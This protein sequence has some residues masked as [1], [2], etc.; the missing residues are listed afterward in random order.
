MQTGACLI[1]TSPRALL[2]FNIDTRRTEQLFTNV[3]I[4]WPFVHPS[5]YLGVSFPEPGYLG[6][7]GGG[8]WAETSLKSRS[9]L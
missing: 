9:N 3:I 2:Y 7:G 4:A 5:S 6:D 8:N 1:R